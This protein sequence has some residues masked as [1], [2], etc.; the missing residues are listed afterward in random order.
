M[1]IF[2][3]SLVTKKTRPE[4]KGGAGGGGRELTIG[5]D[6]AVIKF[7]NHCYC[8]S[9]LCLSLKRDSQGFLN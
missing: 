2:Q 4:R 9:Q 8:V 3:E 1:E 7:E 6:L 5:K